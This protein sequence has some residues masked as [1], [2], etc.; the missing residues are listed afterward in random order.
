MHRLRDAGS[1]VVV[2]AII[3]AIIVTSS[4]PVPLSEGLGSRFC[5]GA[6]RIRA[7]AIDSAI[8]W[9]YHVS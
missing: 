9:A 6:H 4:S 8:R 1:I 7:Q 5:G 3:V 2:L